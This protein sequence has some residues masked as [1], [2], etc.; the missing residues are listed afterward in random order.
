MKSGNSSYLSGNISARPLLMNRIL[1]EYKTTLTENKMKK[2][3]VIVLGYFNPIHRGHLEY[4][5]S[6]ELSFANAGDQNKETIPER[7]ICEKM[8]TALIDG[9]GDKI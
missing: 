6:H 9:L 7:P 2:K 8:G 1:K 3:G 4:G 5:H